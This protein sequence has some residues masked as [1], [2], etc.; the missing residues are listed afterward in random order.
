MR[1]VFTRRVLRE[2]NE[3]LAYVSRQD[4]VTADKMSAAIGARIELCARNPRFGS[5]TD[6]RNVFRAPIS[7]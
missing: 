6:K 2:L 5:A 4:P 1:V 3:L 7:R